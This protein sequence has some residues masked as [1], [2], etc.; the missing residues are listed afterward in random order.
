MASIFKRS[1]RKNEPYLIQYRDHLGKRRTVQG[2]TDKGC[3]EELA[4]KLESEARL[5]TSGLIDPMQDKIAEHKQTPIEGHLAEFEES[6]SDNTQ[7]YVKLTM[8]RVRRIVEGCGFVSLA[9]IDGEPVQAFLRKL[10][11]EEDLGHRTYNHYLQAMDAFCYW[12]LAS[13]RLIANPIIGLER[14]NTATDVRHKRRRC[15]ARKWRS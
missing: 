11:R 1:K 2:F 8:T 7:K 14:L 4:A 9:A 5:R 10:R 6:L 15:Q 12:C 13:K 3:T